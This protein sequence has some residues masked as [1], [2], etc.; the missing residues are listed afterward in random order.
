MLD[1]ACALPACFS[2]IKQRKRKK[3]RLDGDSRGQHMPAHG[4]GPRKPGQSKRSG[5]KRRK[6]SR[7]SLSRGSRREDAAKAPLTFESFLQQRGTPRWAGEG[8]HPHLQV[9]HPN[10]EILRSLPCLA[11]DFWLSTPC[12]NTSLEGMS[13]QNMENLSPNPHLLPGPASE[14]P[15]QGRALQPPCLGLCPPAHRWLQEC[16]TDRSFGCL[17]CVAHCFRAPCL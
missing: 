2:L 10:P 6:K 1:R 14:H 11:T 16:E 13:G 17:S 3:R 8:A 5:A 9:G 12:P 7:D 4:A 15:C